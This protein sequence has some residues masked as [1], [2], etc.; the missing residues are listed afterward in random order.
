[1]IIKFLF[2]VVVVSDVFAIRLPSGVF[3]FCMNIYMA[4]TKIVFV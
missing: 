2:L 4:I 3:D 1:M